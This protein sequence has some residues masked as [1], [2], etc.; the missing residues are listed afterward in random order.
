MTISDAWLIHLKRRV[1]SVFDELPISM[2]AGDDS[3][4]HE[5]EESRSRTGPPV[6]FKSAPAEPADIA[7]DEVSAQRQVAL[8]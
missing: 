8:E 1:L 4:V 6:H 5:T 2:S 7:Q 3:P